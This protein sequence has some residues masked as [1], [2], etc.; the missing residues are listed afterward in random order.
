[1]KNKLEEYLNKTDNPYSIKV[2][3]TTIYFEY[4]KNRIKFEDCIK[5]II[6]NKLIWIVKRW[7]N[8]EIA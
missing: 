7:R 4:S 5:N 1:M 3:D 6:K 8:T 2:G